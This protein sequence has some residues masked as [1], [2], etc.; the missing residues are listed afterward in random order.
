VTSDRTKSISFVRSSSFNIA[1][2]RTI[3]LK[4]RT[5]GATAVSHEIVMDDSIVKSIPARKA[6]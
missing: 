5:G 4:D 1:I 6:F 3:G 2:A